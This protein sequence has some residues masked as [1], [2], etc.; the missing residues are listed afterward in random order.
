MI[1]IPQAT[2]REGAEFIVQR[3]IRAR[4][5]LLDA[6]YC[7]PKLVFSEGSFVSLTYGTALSEVTVLLQAGAEPLGFIAGLRKKRGRP[8]VKAWDKENQKARAQLCRIA[9]SLY[10]HRLITPEEGE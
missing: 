9:N 5:V 10:R 3:L 1:P 4:S 6:G 8:F 7:P 2:I